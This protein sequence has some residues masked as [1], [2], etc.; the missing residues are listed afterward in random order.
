MKGLVLLL[1][2][3]GCTSYNDLNGIKHAKDECTQFKREY[4]SVGVTKPSKEWQT[5]SLEP[6][7][8]IPDVVK[9]VER[10]NG[11]APLENAFQIG[12]EVVAHFCYPL[13]C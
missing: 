8:G 4:D 2:L 13:N 7:N 5:L 1:L 9:T 11:V 10:L 3:M 6:A 12:N